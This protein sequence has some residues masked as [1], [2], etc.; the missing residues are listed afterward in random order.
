MARDAETGRWQAGESP[1]PGGRPSIVMPYHNLHGSR[2]RHALCDLLRVLGP[3]LTVVVVDARGLS[4]GASGASG[5]PDA[6]DLDALTIPSPPDADAE[7]IRVR[8]G[9]RA[10]AEAA[11]IDEGWREV[12]ALQALPGGGGVQGV[13]TYC[14]PEGQQIGLIAWLRL[15]DR[16]ADALKTAVPV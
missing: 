13:P 7:A 3:G 5:R 12:E 16:R 4:L 11:L 9:L 8:A 15:V 10:R 14:G 1:N 6:G 2:A